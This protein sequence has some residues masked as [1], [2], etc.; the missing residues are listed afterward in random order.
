MRIIIP[1]MDDAAPVTKQI[2]RTGS[3]LALRQDTIAS[4]TTLIVDTA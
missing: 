4:K 3:R 1:A 2:V